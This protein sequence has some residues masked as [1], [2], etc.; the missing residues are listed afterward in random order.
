MLENEKDL[1]RWYVVGSRTIRQELKIRDALRQAGMESYVPLQYELTK[2]RNV[3]QRKLVPVMSGLIFVR[4]SYHAFKAYALTSPYLI[5]L[6]RHV[7]GDSD[8]MVVPDRDMERFMALSEAFIDHV[9]YFKPDEVTVHEGELVKIQLGSKEYEAEIKR[10]DGKRGKQ[11]VVEIVGVTTAVFKLTPELMQMITHLSD[12]KQ[13]TLRKKKE[14]ERKK[15]LE[16]SGRLDRRK[17]KNIEMDKKFLFE[18]AY[19]LLFEVTEGHRT[20]VENRMALM[21]VKRTRE[22]LIGCKGII[23]SLEAELALT[24]YLSCVLLNT[25][26]DAAT[27]RMRRVMEQLKGNSML[28]MRLKFYLA[29]LSGDDQGLQALMDEVKGWN[30][31][32][33]S[34]RQKAFLKETE[35]T[36]LSEVRRYDGT[37]VRE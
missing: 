4:A 30:K 27:E 16:E 37:E 5:Y 10:V 31:L 17:T 20:D 21:E 18:T 23:P 13:E 11:L 2:V 15:R 12:K 6:R 34:D 24:M 3:R 29:R 26:V 35:G 33:L 7:Y 14:E 8:Y 28:L 22:R 25:D 19:R 32:R 1:V 36:Q 9:E